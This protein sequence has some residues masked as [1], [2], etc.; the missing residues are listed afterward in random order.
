MKNLV[1]GSGSLLMVVA[2][3]ILLSVVVVMGTGIRTTEKTAFEGTDPFLGSGV[4]AFEFENVWLKKLYGGYV[5]KDVWVRPEKPDMDM[6][7][8]KVDPAL[9][10]TVISVTPTLFSRL[11]SSTS[12]YEAKKVTV[13]VATEAEKDVWERWIRKAEA[14]HFAAKKR[15]QTP[16]PIKRVTPKYRPF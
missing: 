16:S 4:V 10:G 1:L 15:E 9:S 14:A 7:T 2:V 12:F 11:V 3:F 8:V 5:K 13:W 6:V